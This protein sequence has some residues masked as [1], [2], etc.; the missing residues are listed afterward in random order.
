MTTAVDLF[1]LERQP[2][3]HSPLDQGSH[4][5]VHWGTKAILACLKLILDP[6]THTQITTSWTQGI[7]T[8]CT[9]SASEA[10]YQAFRRY[11]NHSSV[12]GNHPKSTKESSKTMNPRLI[13]F[14][15]YTPEIPPQAYI[16][17]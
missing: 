16:Y 7:P 6:D 9:A 4:V 13:D 1:C 15:L 17:V 12:D 8:S 5:G 14:I 3:H 11:G 2:I 10:I